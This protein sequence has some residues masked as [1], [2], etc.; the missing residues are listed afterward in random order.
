MPDQLSKDYFFEYQI[1]WIND[2]RNA[3]LWDKSRRIGAT[4]ADSYR[5]AATAT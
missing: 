1:D 3:L 2:D 5:H 4:Y